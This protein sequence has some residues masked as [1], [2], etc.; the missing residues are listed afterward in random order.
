MGHDTHLDLLILDIFSQI[1]DTLSLQ[2]LNE[3]LSSHYAHLRNYAK[4]KLVRIGS[5]AVPFLVENLN[6]TIQTW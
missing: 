5:K 2:K 4:N 1:Q 6:L 3:T